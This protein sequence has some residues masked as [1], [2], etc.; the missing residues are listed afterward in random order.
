MKKYILNLKEKIAQK[1]ASYFG[2]NHS[3]NFAK[4]VVVRFSQYLQNFAAKVSNFKNKT[5]Q[6]L[7]VSPIA[8]VRNAA[9]ATAE[10]IFDFIFGIA[11][12]LKK[13][14]LKSRIFG[15][16]ASFGSYKD[17]FFGNFAGALSFWGNKQV[18]AA[19]A[20]SL[21]FLVAACLRIAVYFSLS[22]GLGKIIAKHD[23]FLSVEKIELG[24]IINLNQAKI[25]N[26]TITTANG[27]QIVLPQATVETMFLK[28]SDSNNISVYGFDEIFF[29]TKNEEEVKRYK[30][31]YAHSP[32]LKFFVDEKLGTSVLYVD[33]GFDLSYMS[34]DS[35]KLDGLFDGTMDELNGKNVSGGNLADALDGANAA[36]TGTV[37]DAGID[38]GT[39][40]GAS[41]SSNLVSGNR[42][43]DSNNNNNDNGSLLFSSSGSSFSTYTNKEG[44]AILAL[45]SS[46][47]NK[48]AVETCKYCNMATDYFDADIHVS[49]LFDRQKG[50]MWIC[51]IDI[52][53]RDFA[54]S[55]V[56]SMGV[57]SGSGV[58]KIENYRNM[59]DFFGNY[60]LSQSGHSNINEMSVFGVY[61][62]FAK[63][64]LPKIKAAQAAGNRGANASTGSA[65]AGAD[66][67]LEKD[68]TMNI[69]IDGKG[70]TANNV[71]L[72]SFLPSRP[73]RGAQGN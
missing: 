31:K 13:R 50:T 70:I 24:S 8:F 52:K 43:N 14:Q 41:Y 1:F 71:S 64:V 42:D 56:G 20:I 33:K 21:A 6:A 48:R 28:V 29:I 49:I 59:L 60:F 36:N 55:Y 18:V 30:I 62:T 65:G 57:D 51:P 19:L 38:A 3:D 68:I 7:V 10:R 73:L 61:N 17:S 25:I 9:Q 39:D 26:A 54:I 22:Y 44:N 37:T 32:M 23:S 40:T 15:S 72:F 27:S 63:V 67:N 16:P 46:V 58:M 45:D 35:E 53:M 66:S 12:S 47:N 34:S 69:N 5:K 4:R 2:R 11:S